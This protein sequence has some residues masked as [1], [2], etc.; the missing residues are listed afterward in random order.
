MWPPCHSV[1]S[2]DRVLRTF[3]HRQLERC[4][5]RRGCAELRS[6]CLRHLMA[7]ACTRHAPAAVIP[8]ARISAA[9]QCQHPGPARAHFDRLPRALSF[10]HPSPSLT[11][12]PFSTTE[13]PGQAHSGDVFQHFQCAAAA[14]TGRVSWLQFRGP[15]AWTFGPCLGRRSTS[16]QSSLD[17]H[18][19]FRGPEPCQLA[20]ERR[21]LVASVTRRQRA[22]AAAASASRS[23]TCCRETWDPRSGDTPPPRAVRSSGGGGLQA[24]LPA[25]CG[26]GG[27]PRGPPV[28]QADPRRRS[29]R[30]AS[31]A[32]QPGVRRGRLLSSAGAAPESTSGTLEAV[33]QREQLAGGARMAADLNDVESG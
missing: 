24:Q 29:P 3:P 10:M 5:G 21:S 17:A 4:M 12:S 20:Y 11:S 7:R 8:T 19:A 22:A 18:K 33:E 26:A 13:G 32:A 16:S 23:P 25:S 31:S 2:H 6:M 9:S 1:A 15:T 28:I 27:R 14:T 30:P